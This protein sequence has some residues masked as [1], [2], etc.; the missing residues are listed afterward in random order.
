MN[1]IYDKL[2]YQEYVNREN[3]SF[4]EK[5]HVNDLANLVGLH[6][7]HFSRLFKAQVGETPKQFRKHHY[8][9]IYG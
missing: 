6:R 5:I 8:Q 2:V 4:H 3:E 7:S 1:S 9:N